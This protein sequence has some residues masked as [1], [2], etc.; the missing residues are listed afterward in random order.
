[1]GLGTA[2]A[3]GLPA[4]AAGRAGAGGGRREFSFPWNG[5]LVLRREWGCPGEGLASEGSAFFPQAP[6][7]PTTLSLHPLIP[8]PP[9]GRISQRV[10][11]LPR[12][13]EEA[14][15][16]GVGTPSCKGD[17]HSNVLGEPLP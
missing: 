17:G 14:L 3:G 12:V 4:W 5:V 10:A 2:R 15:G 16:N 6:G 13:S 1:M 8:S 7:V 11:S 9:P